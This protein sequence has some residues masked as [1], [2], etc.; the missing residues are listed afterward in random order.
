MYNKVKDQERDAA[1]DATLNGLTVTPDRYPT[2]APVR[3]RGARSVGAASL[4]LPTD[5]GQRGQIH[6]LGLLAATSSC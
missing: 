4:V 6:R 2:V 5:D 3:R 1:V